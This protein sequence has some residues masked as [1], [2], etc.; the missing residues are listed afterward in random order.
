VPDLNP[1]FDPSSPLNLEEMNLLIINGFVVDGRGG[2]LVLGPSHEDGGIPML[3]LAGD[4]TYRYL[5]EL[6]GGEYLVNLVAYESQPEQIEAYNNFQDSGEE[7]MLVVPLS[8]NLLILN[9][10]LHDCYGRCA[11]LLLIDAGQFIVNKYATARHFT[12]IE[13]LN[14]QGSGFPIRLTPQGDDPI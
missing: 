8:R 9:T 11:K 1:K 12:E 6:E 7:G 14:S 4:G 10:Y 2:G 13:R 3:A 5:G